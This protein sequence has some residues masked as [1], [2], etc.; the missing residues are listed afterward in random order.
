MISQYIFTL[1]ADARIDRDRFFRPGPGLVK[2]AGTG[3]SAET[4][5]V[6]GTGKITGTV[7]GIGFVTGTG[8]GKFQI[9]FLK[10]FEF[11]DFN[12]F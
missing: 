12:Y 2:S 10:K 11:F 5:T 7:N 1:N 3:I 9:K 8:T 6:T 4:G